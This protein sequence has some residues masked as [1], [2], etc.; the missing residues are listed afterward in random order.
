LENFQTKRTRKSV[1]YI[2]LWDAL[3]E[4][5]QTDFDRAPST[6]QLFW[7]EAL[8]YIDKWMA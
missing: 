8:R 2:E 3:I 1:D 6:F 5:Y 4:S 7:R